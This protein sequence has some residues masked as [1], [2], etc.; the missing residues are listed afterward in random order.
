MGHIQ[1]LYGLLQKE[2]SNPLKCQFNIF[3]DNLN[4]FPTK[5]MQDTAGKV[6]AYAQTSAREFVAEVYSGLVNGEKYSDDVMK[7]YEKYSNINL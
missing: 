2:A 4:I 6:S 3:R 1:D 5:S 7:L